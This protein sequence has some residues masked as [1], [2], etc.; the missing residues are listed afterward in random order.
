ML[1]WNTIISFKRF[2]QKH[3]GQDAR[4]DFRRDYDKSYFYPDSDDC[5]T[6]HRYFHFPKCFRTQQT[7]APLEVSSGRSIGHIVGMKK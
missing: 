4:S 1:D 2:G 7:Y 6:K 3:T 5:K